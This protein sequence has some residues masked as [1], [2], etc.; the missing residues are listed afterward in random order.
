MKKIFLLLS[1]LA[2]GFMIFTGQKSNDDPKWNQDP[3]MTAAYP[4]GSYTPLPVIHNVLDP[5]RTTRYFS[6]PIGMLA[7]TPN[8]IS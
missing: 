5:N 6:T 4:V 8:F 2:A 3:R 1:F 7:V